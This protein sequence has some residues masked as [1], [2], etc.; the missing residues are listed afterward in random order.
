MDFEDGGD[1]PFMEYVTTKEASKKVGLTAHRIAEL[2]KL[3]VIEGYKPG[4]KKWLVAIK[5][6]GNIHKLVYK[7]EREV[8]TTQITMEE[9]E[10]SLR[11]K[12]R[13]QA[14]EKHFDDIRNL[15]G[16]WRDQLY[17]KGEY[18]PVPS[19][20]PFRAAEVKPG[21][22][23]ERGAFH[24]LVNH[25]GVA[26]IWFDVEN[27][28]LFKALNVHLPDKELWDDYAKL[29]NLLCTEI[30]SASK[31]NR[32]EQGERYIRRLKDLIYNIDTKLETATLKG[33]FPSKCDYCPD[34]V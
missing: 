11:I 31:L 24:W 20:A 16:R 2:A 9:A 25:D 22:E 26:T 5:A 6:E 4:K 7:T 12:V 23:Y 21:H 1:E 27:E 34:K 19:L 28:P 30:E 15:I 10:S 3:E 32:M 14:L 29:K 13:K 18:V 8:A 33:V 17:P